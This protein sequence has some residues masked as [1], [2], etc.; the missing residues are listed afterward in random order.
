MKSTDSAIRE[1][2][3]QPSSSYFDFRGQISKRVITEPQPH[4][5]DLALPKKLNSIAIVVTFNPDKIILQNLQKLAEIF[6]NF[7]IIDNSPQ[8]ALNLISNSLPLV[9]NNL[10][11]ENK[12]KNGLAGALNLGIRKAIS[13]FPNS[14]LF[15]FDQ[16]SMLK[17]GFFENIERALSK[18]TKQALGNT[19]YC[20]A[21]EHAESFNVPHE[22]NDREDLTLV[23]TAITSGSFLW[24]KGIER[25]GLFI[26]EMFIDSL[27]HE[28][29]LR[30]QRFGFKIK[31]IQ[32]ALI[33]HSL[34][35]VK[36]NHFLGRTLLTHNHAPFRWYFF[37]RNFIFS[38]AENYP[39]SKHWFFSYGKTL[40][41]TYIKVLL[42]EENRF[43]KSKA[44][45]TGIIDGLWLVY[46]KNLKRKISK[47]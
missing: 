19:I 14:W 37:T 16:D 17:S 38:C 23:P 4:A 12:N 28:F 24:I 41:K 35:E 18:E 33:Y 25:I 13:K 21:F 43:R 30:A 34:G 9:K 46:G 47:F 7:I 3:T 1:W 29:C 5:K 10:I 6:E 42:F 44:A 45:L 8:S 15:F 32:K 11:I 40:L 31:L 22:K 2:L 36:V 39:L 20:C 27:D 26:E